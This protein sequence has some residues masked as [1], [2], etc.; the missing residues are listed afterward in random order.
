MGMKHLWNKYVTN[1]SSIR[2]SL[3]EHMKRMVH[4]HLCHIQNSAKIRHCQWSQ[5]MLWSCR[6][7]FSREMQQTAFATDSLTRFFS[8]N[9]IWINFQQKIKLFS[10]CVYLHMYYLK[11][12]L[13]FLIATA[14]DKFRERDFSH[15]AFRL[16]LPLRWRLHQCLTES[17]S[18]CL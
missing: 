17:I 6:F 10:K 4:R 2:Q 15:D 3:I 7:Q 16:H 9:Q 1:V 14:T 5:K 13:K 8:I 18:L 11:L 12:Q